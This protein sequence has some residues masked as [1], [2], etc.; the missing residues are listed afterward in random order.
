MG[1]VAVNVVVKLDLASAVPLA[2]VDVDKRPNK[3]IA[4]F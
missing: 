4:K 2:F 1:M 3:T